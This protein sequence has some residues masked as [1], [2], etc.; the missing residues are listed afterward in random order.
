MKYEL[1]SQRSNNQSLKKGI[2]QGTNELLFHLKHFY[3]TIF[4]KESRTKLKRTHDKSK[5]RLTNTVN[6]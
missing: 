4:Q 3:L 6:I 2:H 1:F 5:D